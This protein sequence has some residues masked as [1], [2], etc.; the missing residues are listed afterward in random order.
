MSKYEVNGSFKTLDVCSIDESKPSNG[1]QIK[2]D[3][4]GNLNLYGEILDINYRNG[5]NITNSGA[6]NIK[7]LDDIVLNSEEGHIT[8]LAGATGPEAINIETTDPTGGMTVNTGTGGILMNTDGVLSLISYDDMTMISRGNDINIGYSDNSPTFDPTLETQNINIEAQNTI[9]NTSNDFQVVASDTITFIAPSISFGPD[10]TNPFIRILDDCLLID[11]ASTIG[12]K[13]VMID[14]ESTSV[15]KPGYNGILI[16]SLN[17]DISPDINLI[18]NNGQKGISLGIEAPNSVFGKNENFVAYKI[19]TKI[20]PL[21]YDYEFSSSYIGQKFYWVSDDVSEIITGV[22]GYITPAS[23]YTSEILTTSGDYTNNITK[24]YKVAIDNTTRPTNTFK[25]SND[26]GKTY[27][28]ELINTSTSDIT[29]EDGIK[30]KFDKTSGFNENTYWTFTALPVATTDASGDR[31]SQLARTIKAGMGYITVTEPQDF[32]IK[33]SDQERIRIT[34]NGQVGVG[35]SKPTGTFEVTNNVG[36][37]IILSTNYFDNQINPSVVGLQ[38]GGWVAVWENYADNVDKYDV[39]AQIF[40]PDGTRNGAQ[41]K[42]NSNSDSANNQCFPHIA[43]SVKPSS[44][45]FMIVWSSDV[46]AIGTYNIKGQIYDADLPEESRKIISNDIL[47]NTT[48]TNSNKYPRVASLNIS[49]KGYPYGVVWSSNY[50]SGGTNNDCYL[51]IVSYNGNIIN[52]EYK[53]NTTTALSQTYP[54]ISGISNN[55][56]TI[57]GGFVVAFM[58]EYEPNIYDIRYQLFDRNYSPY[59]SEVSIANTEPNPI[60][61]SKTYGRVAVKGLLTGGF[62]IAYNKAYYGDSS[63]L[64]VGDILSGSTSGYNG[65][66]LAI[67]PDYPTKIKV[68]MDFIDQQ[69]IIGEEFTTD[70]SKRLEKIESVAFT[71]TVP[72]FGTLTGNQVEITLSRDVKVIQASYF[73]TALTTPIYTIPSVNTTPFIDDEELQQQNTTTWDRDNTI[74]TYYYNLPVMT[75][76]VDGNFVICWSNGKIP[77]IYYQKFE[78]SNGSKI[79]AETMLDKAANGVKQRNPSIASVTNKNGQ[80]QGFVIV[81]DAETFDTSQQ[82]VFGELVNNDYPL[83]KVWNGTSSLNLMNY[84]Y[85]GLGIETPESILHINS[86]TPK[87][88]LQNSNDLIGSGLGSSSLIFRDA[89]NNDFVEI[90]GCYATSYETRNPRFE[91]LNRWFK[92]DESGGAFSLTAN[93]SSKNNLEAT[94]VNFNPIEDWVSGKINNALQFRGNSYVNCGNHP[95]I[96][97]IAPTGFSISCWTKI[98]LGGSDGLQNT[99]ISTG[100]TSSGHYKLVV[101]SLN[102]LVGTIYTDTTVETITSTLTIAD[103][104]WH[105]L[106]MTYDPD[107]SLDQIKLY[108][109]GVVNITHTILPGVVISVPGDVVSVYIGTLDEGS[110]FFIGLIDDFRVYGIPLTSNDVTVLY[111]NISKVKGKL[112]FKSNNGDGIPESDFI[113]NF[114]ID[115]EG[116]IENLRTRSL[117]DT[118][119]TGTLT[120]TDTTI[121]GTNGTKFTTELNIGDS[122]TING[123]SRI[124]T[125]IESDTVCT[126]NETY[127]TFAS[128]PYNNIQRR[129][130][131]LTGLDANS[132]LRLLLTSEGRLAIGRAD[133]GAKLVISGTENIDDYPNIYFKNYSTS[134]STN[135]IGFYGRDDF[136]TPY[137]ITRIQTEGGLNSGT[138]ESG[139]FK[140]YVNKTNTMNRSLI[141]DGNGY[142]GLGGITEFYPTNHLEI[143]DNT[144][145]D[146]N[147]LLDSASSD[148]AIGGAASNIKFK[149]QN[150]SVSYATIKGS[151][152]STLNN[153]RGRLDFITSNGSEDI[154]RMTIKSNNGVS[155]YLPEPVNS[156]HVSPLDSDFN[157]GT[158]IASASSTTINGTGTAFSSSLIGKIIYFL[159]SKFSRVITN[160]TNST[161][162]TISEDVGTDAIPSQSY[163]IY[164]PG[165]NMDSDGYVGIGTALQTSRLHLNGSLASGVIKITYAD[166]TAGIYTLTDK[167]Y[168]TFFVDAS[169]GQITMNLP[170]LSTVKGRIYNFKKIDTSS[171][172]VV[173]N[174]NNPELIDQVAQYNLTI[175]FQCIIIQSSGDAGTGRWYVISAATVSTGTIANTD[176]LPQGSINLYYSDS[177]VSSYILNNITT[178]DIPE[179]PPP[180]ANLYF[181][182]QRAK[183]AV[184]DLYTAVDTLSTAFDPIGSAATVQSSLT[185]VINNL[186]SDS[187][188]EGVTNLYCSNTNVANAIST[189]VTTQTLTVSGD[190][191][192]TVGAVTQVGLITDPVT[193]NT[194]NGLI[195][196]VQINLSPDTATEFTVNNNNIDVGDLVF[197]MVNGKHGSPQSGLLVPIVSIYN[198]SFESFKVILRNP[199]GSTA[200]T[201]V[202]D[203]AFQIIRHI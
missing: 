71:A 24:Y 125:N 105:N 117:P 102:Q 32:Q 104:S 145:N 149:S 42:V 23:T 120:P 77:S 98:F 94:L 146:V 197:A 31:D 169:G 44:G 86:D 37:R 67:D 129:P 110:D 163:Q 134:G 9:S 25:W 182:N 164:I 160:V 84:G 68:D 83:M 167:D 168:H 65:T 147:V 196:T 55:D 142:L 184:S 115:S 100:G 41:F 159:D 156:F 46:D 11:S 135:L 36:K 40:Y 20:I 158:V 138:I 139:Y 99:I 38:N 7:T 179:G 1:G 148:L 124:I 113:R 194:S 12:L 93:D 59:G 195:T 3:V 136:D 107:L 28:E 60:L 76:T 81:Y 112:V 162:L 52:S 18:N 174:G 185:S 200:C 103:G 26:G 198:V 5:V 170:S 143:K 2:F 151:S 21:Q 176:D 165:L 180:T 130:S 62:L 175:P 116:F 131:V 64:Q 63:R 56:G 186:T 121:T 47:I 177:L 119:L 16:R 173:L 153:S 203:I 43:A 144:S 187:I 82:G 141:L 85:L 10:L 183:D 78:F 97:E 157:P 91:D 122:I 90:K 53:V 69:F 189:S 80:N 96:S 150:V 133:T 126:V 54:D 27:Q 87:V 70:L 75:E 73:S 199:S 190:T 95:T 35:I 15:S 29:L 202:Y 13:K 72:S 88:I 111:E 166:T 140:V 127:N 191:I 109:D 101:N 30:I 51:Q 33:T 106:I 161:T 49:E 79:G 108:I 152:D 22:S 118:T 6:F 137:E 17:D 181:T 58:N 123:Y 172:I 48:I 132:N 57:Q 171:N 8:L 128:G 74:F 114:T 188:T 89:N 66:L 192:K 39:Y 155:F 61:P 201:G 178:A 45:R 154:T 4:A 50:P 14:C 19:G 34:D 92:F 193:I